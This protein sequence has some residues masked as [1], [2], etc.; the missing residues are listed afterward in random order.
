VTYLEELIAYIALDRDDEARLRSLHPILEPH[1]RA[2]ADRFYEA[3]WQNPGAASVLSGPAQVERLRVTLIEWMS[4][5]LLGPYDERFYEK[6]S[7]IGRRHVA[8]G[9]RHQYMFTAMNVMRSA[10]SD[11][12]AEHVPAQAITL[13]RSVNKLLDIELAI[14]MRHYQLDSEDKLIARERRVQ[15]IV[16][17]NRPAREI[18][19]REPH[20]FA[21]D[22]I[23]SRNY[24][25]HIFKKFSKIRSPT[26]PDFSA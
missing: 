24:L 1:F 22:Q 16:V 26:A 19:L 20:A 10:Y 2:I 9:L 14:A 13:M 11:V 23:D 12:I 5:G 18:A 15:G 3:V 6:R 7:R 17:I 25:D 4:S 8:I 21:F